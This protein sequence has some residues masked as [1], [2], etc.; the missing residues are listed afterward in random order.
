VIDAEKFDL[1][2]R[3]ARLRPLVAKEVLREAESLALIQITWAPDSDALLHDFLF[4]NNSKEGVLEAVGKIFPKLHPSNVAK[5]SLEIL[6]T[7]L[8][9]PRSVEEI[10]NKLS[11]S[12]F[13]EK[14]IALTIRL[15]VDLG[16]VS[17]TEEKEGGTALLFN[18]YAFEKNAE[19]VY[20]AIKT[21]PP[22][23]H[24]EVLRIVESVRQNPGIPLPN[25]TNKKIL[26][27][28]VKLGVID[29]SKISTRTLD[30][31]A[32]FAT[33]PHI[34]GVFDKSAG[35]DLSQDLV[36]DSKLLLNSFRYGEYYSSPGRGQIKNPVWIVNALLRD[37]AIGVQ[38]PATAIGEDYPL[39]LSRGIVNVVES[40]LHPGRYSMELLKTDV[41]SAVIEV[42]QQKTLLPKEITP[43]NEE[44]ARAGQFMS[45]GAVRVEQEIPEELKKYH[46]EM[47]F[48]LRTSRRKR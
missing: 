34:W 43:S 35:T 12:G 20:K 16:L 14:D 18:P 28:L 13:Q 7:T 46:E 44:I 21:L 3:L 25:K 1:H 26:G 23:E 30:R 15:I 19:D 33:A 40:R 32:Y 4:Q 8:D 22:A 38:R 2:R 6:G 37:G 17:K 42:L 29:Y 45:P 10:K 48:A 9:L 36:D 39:A 47:I 27:L 5:A 31:G 11:T 41:A 24:D